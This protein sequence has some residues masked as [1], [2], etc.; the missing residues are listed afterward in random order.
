MIEAPPRLAAAVA[1]RRRRRANR[2]PRV[3][4]ELEARTHCFHTICKQPSHKSSSTLWPIRFQ[5]SVFVPRPPRR[6]RN[7]R[8]S[9]R[10]LLLLAHAPSS[11][12]PARAPP[13]RPDRP[14][15]AKGVSGTEPAS[16]VGE[17]RSKEEKRRRRERQKERRALHT[18]PPRSPRRAPTASW[19]GGGRKQVR[20]ILQAGA[21]RARVGLQL[22]PQSPSL[23]APKFTQLPSAAPSPPS[24]RRRRPCGEPGPALA[25]SG[26]RPALRT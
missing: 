21:P 12:P 16:L 14:D 17:G 18:W 1:Q 2:R 26:K 13:D 10:R 20:E 22:T 15:R 24:P 25:P 23:P 8:I 7:A 9:P 19:A 6:A 4:R 11:P 3:E 5:A